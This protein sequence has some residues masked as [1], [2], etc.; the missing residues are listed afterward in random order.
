MNSAALFCIVYLLFTTLHLPKIPQPHFFFSS[1][2]FASLFVTFLFKVSCLVTR[3]VSRSVLGIIILKRC[4]RVATGSPLNANKRLL[5]LS[6]FLPAVLFP[7]VILTSRF[8]LSFLPT[9]PYIPLLCICLFFWPVV[10]FSA[11]VF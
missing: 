6:L 10:S 5:Y 4:Y 7:T 2:N 1:Y 11:F 3:L 9:T 8:C